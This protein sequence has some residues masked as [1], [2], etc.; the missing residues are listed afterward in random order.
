MQASSIID[1]TQKVLSQTRRRIIHNE[2][3]PVA[4]KGCSIFE[5][6][7]DIILKGS[8]DVQFGHKLNI[9]TGKSGLVLD[10]VLEQGKLA[11]PAQLSPMI[12]RNK[13]STVK[14]P[15]RPGRWWLRQST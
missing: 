14:C 9:T 3:V 4:Q 7:I 12:T 10:I 11:D 8:R 6:H 15:D 5:P 1:L 13:P 2:N